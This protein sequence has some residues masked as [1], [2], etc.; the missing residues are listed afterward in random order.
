MRPPE[1]VNRMT[2][3]WSWST[4]ASN[5]GTAD[6]GI[7]FAEGQL[8][9]TVNDSARVLMKRVAELL[10][11]LSCKTA[12]TGSSG[13]YALA[14]T[15]GF[16]AYA[17]GLIVGFTANHTNSGAA[18]LNCNSIGAKA[19]YASGEALEG[20]EIISGACYVLAYDT[21]LNAAAGGW[22]LI[23]SPKKLAELFAS[24]AI[25]GNSDSNPFTSYPSGM[26]GIGGSSYPDTGIL[27]NNAMYLPI[28][29][30]NINNPF[31]YGGLDQA[32][33][34]SVG[35][36]WQTRP[37]GTSGFTAPS[38]T[39]A[40]D[41]FGASA[42]L[43]QSD[44]RPNMLRVAGTFAATTFT[45]TTAF[46]LTD[47]I[48]IKKGM[49]IRTNDEPAFNGQIASWTV[50]GSDEVDQI[51]VTNWY[52]R[53]GGGISGTPSGTHAII[54]PQ[55]KMW[56][57]LNTTFLNR[58]SFTGTA[59]A[60]SATVTSVSSSAGIVP[61]GTLCYGL[62]GSSNVVVPHGTVITG[63]NS[64]GTTIF[65]SDESTYSGTVT[66]YATTGSGLGSGVASEVDVH[67]SGPNVVPTWIQDTGDLTSGSYDVANLT[68]TSQWRAGLAVYGTG[69]SINYVTSVDYTTNAMTLKYKATV[70]GTGVALKAQ[71]RF[72]EGGTGIDMVA[73]NNYS[74][75]GFLSR[76]SWTYGFYS[77][78]GLEDGF[79]CRPDTLSGLPKY[80][81]RVDGRL[82]GFPS[83][84]AMAVTSD[85]YAY[86]G[87]TGAGNTLQRGNIVFAPAG[88]ATPAENG[89]AT[90]ELTS[91]T[92]LKIKV[93]GSDGTVRSVTLTLA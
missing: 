42:L 23:N 37:G 59:T 44:T 81:F 74:A 36:G 67:N 12:S 78:G 82:N 88:S 76:G 92:Q 70:T 61:N 66:F 22:H 3:I 9:A 6:S 63:M 46:A 10:A 86:W 54:N 19:I 69:P 28:G 16:T 60:S 21:A 56:T 55:D 8:A 40:Y 84:Y 2:S 83:T 20:G 31:P 29:S 52:A 50:N 43:V 65:L 45:P 39:A 24:P 75:S 34:L 11:D 71:N 41:E 90:F 25:Y 32:Q 80:G 79:I 93:K 18:T 1:K 73:V 7:N 33:G 68:L 14:T 30:V 64:A 13:T 77:M 87:V 85:T 15:A 58:I 62:D 48:R 27:Q 4:T 17:D 53:G 35:V 57:E 49:W 72:D 38:Q 89:Y 91:D 26:Y 51:T 47:D 5:N